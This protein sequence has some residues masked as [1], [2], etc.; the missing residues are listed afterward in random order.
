MKQMKQLEVVEAM[1]EKTSTSAFKQSLQQLMG[2]K[3]DDVIGL[4]KQ[5]SKR[6]K[7]AKDED[8]GLKEL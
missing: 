4:L 2:A 7:E 5:A 1:L 6:V 3:A 8:K